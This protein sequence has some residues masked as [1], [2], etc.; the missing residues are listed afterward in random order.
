VSLSCP[1]QPSHGGG[2]APP[3]PFLVKRVALFFSR[4]GRRL[5]EKNAAK[6]R[7]GTNNLSIRGGKEQ[8]NKKHT[9]GGKKKKREPVVPKKT[10]TATKTKKL[11]YLSEEKGGGGIRLEGK[12]AL[13]SGL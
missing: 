11:S 2:W 9:T 1:L 6:I 8:F 10:C 5:G 3:F 4:K 7:K 13:R 12:G